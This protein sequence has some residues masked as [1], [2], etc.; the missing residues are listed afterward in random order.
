M[1]QGGKPSI[2]VYLANIFQVSITLSGLSEMELMP[3]SANQ[4]AKSGW[5]LGPWP[6]IPTY[7]PWA[8]QAAIAFFSSTLT[9]GSRSSMSVASSS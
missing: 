5:S 1:Q 3:S 2:V 8:L 6:Q 9:A 7:L 4:W